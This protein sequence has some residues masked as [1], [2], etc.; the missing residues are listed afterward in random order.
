LSYPLVSS[1]LFSS[2]AP[3]SLFPVHNSNIITEYKVKSSLSI[4]PCHDHEL[5][6]STAYT[7]YSI[8]QVPKIVC[9]PFFLMVTS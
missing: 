5:T 6:L 4:S 2:S 1:I 8:H 3:I 7:E 9:F